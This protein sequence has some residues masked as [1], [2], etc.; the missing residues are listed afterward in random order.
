VKSVIETDAAPAPAGA[1]SQA[2]VC[3]D[4][5]F[6]AGQIPTTPSGETIHDQPIESQTRQCLQ[7][8]EEVI[9]EAGLELDDVVKVTVFL[10]DIENL[11]AMDE[12]Y[13]EYFDADP[14]ARSAIA[15]SGIAKNVD[16]EI[17]AIAVRDE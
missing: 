6:T 8:I 13:T 15:V 14:P 11:E 2:I 17:E 4:F 12:I 3:E 16:I 10:N 9:N 5:V 7:N 1:Y